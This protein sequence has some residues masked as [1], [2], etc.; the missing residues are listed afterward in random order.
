[1]KNCLRIILLLFVS[2]AI[3]AQ[4]STS[5]APVEDCT[6][7]DQINTFMLNSIPAIGNAGCGSN[8]YNSFSSPVWTLQIGNSYNYSA[9]VG[10]GIYL[11]AFAI[12]I[13]F[14]NNS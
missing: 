4:C 7:G 8:G 9:T 2:S 5:T 13:D 6:Y 14:N 1:M 10:S 12:W 11:E 3:H